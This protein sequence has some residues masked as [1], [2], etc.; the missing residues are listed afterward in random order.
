M[1]KGSSSG[2]RTHALS[3]LQH[4]IADSEVRGMAVKALEKIPN[5]YL[6]YFMPQLVQALKFE[7]HHKNALGDMLLSRAIKSTRIVGHAYFWALNSAL[8]DPYSFERLYL[9]YERFLFLCPHYRK[10]L[11]IQ[12]RINEVIIDTNYMSINNLHM[13]VDELTDNI[14]S[15]IEKVKADLDID[16][17]ILPHVPDIPLS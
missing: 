8:H 14:N 2:K 4:E 13:K 6:A 16:Y 15:E 1:L 11:C 9:H 3:L 7:A 5:R 17:F 10:E 12:T